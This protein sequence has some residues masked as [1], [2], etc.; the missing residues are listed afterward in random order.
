MPALNA[1]IRSYLGDPW[2]IPRNVLWRLRKTV[3]HQPLVFVVGAPRSGTTLMQRVLASHS[4]LFSIESET[5]IFSARN[6]F[7]RTHFELP[8]GDCEALFKTSRSRTEFFGA[9]VG[10]LQ[11]RNGGRLFVEKTPQHVRYLKTLVPCF[12]KAKFVQMVRDGRDCFCSARHHPNI[13]Q[14]RSPKTFA[15]YWRSCVRA[16]LPL[17]SHEHLYTLRY[18]DFVE[19]PSGRLEELMSFLGLVAEPRQLA[20]EER[21]QDRR[22][23]RPQFQRLGAAI[24]GS[25]VGRWRSE[26]AQ[27]EVAAFERI[28]GAELR[29]F[30]YPLVAGC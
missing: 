5:G 26:L 23:S 11:D 21:G 25:T 28:A 29:H 4:Q 15:R 10:L 3:S 14:R 20:N 7:N 22:S 12:P 6:L 27:S 18:E 9:G 13:P 17:E 2:S 1:F 19:N 8:R 24:D 16:A 30:H